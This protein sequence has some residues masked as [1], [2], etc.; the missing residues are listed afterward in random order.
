MR[1]V[2]RVVAWTLGLWRLAL[3]RI[4]ADWRFLI[5]VWLLLA[6]STTLLA[7]GV[8]YGDA[9]AVGS[10]RSAIRSAPLGDQGVSAR[11]AVTGTQLEGIDGAIR[12]AMEESLGE[13]AGV[14]SLVARSGSYIR[15]G[16]ASATGS[17]LTLLESIDDPARHATL[18]DGR[19]PTPRADPVE[20]TISAAAGDAMQI[21][22]GDRVPLGDA[23]TPGADP[24]HPVVT[25]LVVGIHRPNPADPAWAGDPLDLT[26]TGALNGRTFV[27][28]FLVQTPDLVAPGSTS[29]IDATWR[30]SIDLD[31]LTADEIEPLRAR[32][33]GLP[34]TIHRAFPA[35]TSVKVTAGLAALLDGIARSLQ[36]AR[37]AVFLLTLQFAVVAI[38]A[39]LLVAGMLVD[40]RRPE[41]GLLRSRG[42]STGH[43][44]SL[45]FGEALLLAIPAVVVAPFAAS[46]VVRLLGQVGPLA[47]TGA[48][49]GAGVTPTVVA[50]V[51][52]AGFVAAIVLTVPALVAG[53]EVAGIRAVLGRPIARTFA[54]RLGIDVALVVVAAI[55][56]WQLRTYGVPLTR[57]ANGSLGFDPLLIAAPAFGLLAGGVVATRAVP[58]LGEIG[59]RLLGGMRGLVSPLGARQIARRPLRYTRAALLLMLSTAL[60]TF[61]AVYAATWSASQADQAAYQVGADVR[62]T[63]G[64]GTTVPSWQLGAAVRSL[65]GVTA[66]TPVTR[67]DLSI[68]SVV[69]NGVLL[70]AD[71]AAIANIATLP[72][73]PEA[74]DLGPGLAALAE[75][76][77]KTTGIA[78][79]A[80]TRWLR[81]TVDADLTKQGPTFTGDNGQSVTID[82]PSD[83]RGIAVAAVVRDADGRLAKF[84]MEASSQAGLWRG[85]NQP[86]VVPLSSSRIA[87]PNGAASDPRTIIGLEISLLDPF[88]TGYV[89][90]IHGTLQ[91]DG[92]DGSTSETP[93]AWQ[94]LDLAPAAAWPWLGQDVNDTIQTIATGTNVVVLPNDPQFVTGGDMNLRFL[95][96]PPADTGVPVLGG[97]RLLA[98]AGSVIG[99]TLGARSSGD[100]VDLRVI[101]RT[102]E[103]PTIA[104]GTT[105]AI[106]DAPTIDLLAYL[107]GGSIVTGSEWWLTTQPGSLEAITTGLHQPGFPAV[108]IIDRA[109]ALAALESD[110]VGLATLGALILG[111]IAAAA[112]AVLGYVVGASVSTRE[113]LG[114]FALLRALGLSTR[115]L[116]GWLAAEQ[117]FLLTI[118]VVAGLAIGVLLGVLIVPET[119]LGPSGA[120][121]VPVPRVVVPWPLLAAVGVGAVV[122]LLLTVALVGRPLPGRRVAAVLRTSE[123]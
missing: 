15:A 102:P 112:F 91:I 111:A 21:H 114:E 99:D 105:F 98:A 45:A 57:S 100:E 2:R 8:V 103:F 41:I 52:V 19:W 58:R 48:V 59:E 117:A 69:R 39:V 64:P 14:V 118:G 108:T 122:V 83:Y 71:T 107:G 32:I 115:Q 25:V 116:T 13:P 82:V 24:N 92:A 60:G 20:A 90:P 93:S 70:A 42:A 109:T 120:T 76:R 77:P 29:R 106:A 94:G 101:G 3:G 12:A 80:G 75:A 30:A 5:G 123:E 65:P 62:V 38:Y 23:A 4:R 78:I 18:V 37:G 85:R 36:V 51:A 17:A 6:C 28:P 10:L 72:S 53:V 68:G 87:V 54:Q 9:V 110:P 1:A 49:A 113:R 67:R 56:I 47:S 96:P 16:S 95:A 40:R 46:A 33:G 31:R 97:D 7:A 44:V 63:P 121:V 43:V 84:E 79:P 74:A 26:G 73:G 22:L 81:L 50:A 11:S 55:A 34:E 27:G 35:G 104:P 89:S 61:G 66:A 88:G 86:I 119:L